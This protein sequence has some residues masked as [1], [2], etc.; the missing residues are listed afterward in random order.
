VAVLT[1]A[2]KVVTAFYYSSSGGRT[3][4]SADVFGVPVAYLQS[5]DD[6]WDEVSPFHRW[7]PHVFTAVALTKAFG[8]SSTVTD[9]SAVQTASGRPSTLLLTT[10]DGA[11]VE[12]RA[13]DVRARLGL[14]ST[15]FRLGVLGSPAWRRPP[16]ARRAGGIAHDVSAVLSSPPTAHWPVAACDRATGPSR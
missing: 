8:L 12:L 5:V 4:A 16:A 15:A 2:G 13:A 9:V 1:Y 10:R 14:R 6:P 3:A 7:E 11:T